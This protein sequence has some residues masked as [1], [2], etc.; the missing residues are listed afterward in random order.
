MLQTTTGYYVIPGRPSWAKKINRQARKLVPKIHASIFVAFTLAAADAVAGDSFK[1]PIAEVNLVEISTAYRS[2]YGPLHSSARLE[3][4]GEDRLAI[5]SLDSVAFPKDGVMPD[6]TFHLTID[7]FKIENRGIRLIY[8]LPLDTVTSDSSVAALPSGRLLVNTGRKIQVFDSSLRVQAEASAEH[9][10]ALDAEPNRTVAYRIFLF[11]ASERTGVIGFE[12]P[13]Y[14]TIG[15][16]FPVT[17]HTCWFSTDDLRPIA[18]T[19]AVV[20][21]SGTARELLFSV[22]PF[23]L[24]PKGREELSIPK[25]EACD[26]KPQFPEFH[27]LHAEPASEVF[28]RQG[29]ISILRGDNATDIRI[30]GSKRW[31]MG[32]QAWNAPLAIFFGG[33]LK[34]S[35]LG[36]GVSENSNTRLV[37]YDTGASAEL[38]KPKGNGLEHRIYALSP[39]GGHLAILDGSQLSIYDVPPTLLGNGSH[40]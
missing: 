8:G 24:S 3:F 26:A 12:K 28:C 34:F 32:A 39:S 9:V 35:L 11:P 1:R 33:V 7:V 30:P 5:S 6:S 18:K 17:G 27:L 40:K 23:A 36:G 31:A 22:G 21:Q 19:N 20:A 38:P 14:R 15:K 37:N 29:F 16:A 4:V 25:T 10:C 13:W 2:A